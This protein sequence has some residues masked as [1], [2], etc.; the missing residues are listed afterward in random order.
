MPL[1]AGQTN[2]HGHGFFGESTLSRLEREFVGMCVQIVRELFT[3]YAII[4]HLG[5]TCGKEVFLIELL[6]F[7]SSKDL[8]LAC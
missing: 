7:M 5:D 4:P 6:S 1:A 3:C 2:G 8:K